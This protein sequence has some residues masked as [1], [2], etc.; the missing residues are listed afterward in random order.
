MCPIFD[1][2]EITST[3][4][5]GSSQWHLLVGVVFLGKKLGRKPVNKEA[6]ATFLGKMASNLHPLRLK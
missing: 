2:C 5:G 3:I 4:H 1:G 6:A